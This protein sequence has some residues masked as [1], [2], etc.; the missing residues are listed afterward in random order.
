[1]HWIACQCVP[2]GYDRSSP[3]KVLRCTG[4]RASACQRGRGNAEEESA[5]GRGY[6][7]KNVISYVPEIIRYWR[8]ELSPVKRSRG[9]T[10]HLWS[11]RTHPAPRLRPPSTAFDRACRLLCSPTGI[12]LETSALLQGRARPE[13]VRD[14]RRGRRRAPLWAIDVVQE[15]L[16]SRGRNMLEIADQLKN[17]I[18]KRTMN[19]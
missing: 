19:H 9:R 3:P 5:P 8:T 18:Q 12:N 4:S 13:T 11:A 10:S 15:A 6:G 17:E 7:A 1:M 16:R 2:A 14:W